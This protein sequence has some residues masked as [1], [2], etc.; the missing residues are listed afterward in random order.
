MSELGRRWRFAAGAAL[1]GASLAAAR[2]PEIA[3]REERVFRAANGASDRIRIPVRVLMQAGTFATVPAAAAV[4]WAAHRRSLARSLALGGT[5]AWLVVKA[6]KPFGGRAR[7]AGV[8]EALTIREHIAGDLGWPSGHAAVAT[9]LAAILAPELP[10]PAAPVLVGVVGA[11]GFGRMYVG[12]H[13]PHDLIGGLGLGLIVS[14][15]FG[16]GSR[17]APLEP[18]SAASHP[19]S[20]TCTPNGGQIAVR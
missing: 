5:A 17:A 2:R 11:V 16:G 13:L 18:R 20:H 4:A 6:L 14:A 3:V 19:R 9:T 8:L 10:A 15:V 12:A 7:P 1:V